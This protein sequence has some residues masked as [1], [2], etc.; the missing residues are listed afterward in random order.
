[1]EQ[2]PVELLETTER[3]RFSPHCTP[4]GQFHAIGGAATVFD[5]GK[6]KAA[7]ATTTHKEAAKAETEAAAGQGNTLVLL[8]L[9]FLYDGKG[10]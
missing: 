8:F 9:V 6:A 10:V 4:R 2:P 3:H 7:K 5:D 1:M